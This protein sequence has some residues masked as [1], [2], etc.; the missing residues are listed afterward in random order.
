MNRIKKMNSIFTYSDFNYESV[1]LPFL[2]WIYGQGNLKHITYINEIWFYY[3]R[4]L[5]G[6]MLYDLYFLLNG[7][8]VYD[9]YSRNGKYEKYL[10]F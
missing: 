2:N 8:M 1:E 6:D 4:L 3:S 9:L 10:Y 5:N 7:D